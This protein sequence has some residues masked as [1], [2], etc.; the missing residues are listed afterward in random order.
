MAI[1]VSKIHNSWHIQF[2]SDL[3]SHPSI[4]TINVI[5]DQDTFLMI[6]VYNPS[7]CTSLSPLIHAK[8]PHHKVIVSGDFNLYHPLWSKPSHASKIS[9]N[10]ELLVDSIS[11]KGFLP[12]NLPGVETFFWKDYSSVLDL[13]WIFTPISPHISDF[14][15]NFPMFAGSDHNPLFNLLIRLAL[16]I[17]I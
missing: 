11:S 13:T 7:D 17:V 14:E 3:F 12:L 10:S 15:V 8:L 5:T 6:N 9:D 1:Y 4:I 16:A 2:R